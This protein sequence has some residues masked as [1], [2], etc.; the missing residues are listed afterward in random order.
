MGYHIRFY[1][2]SESV[3]EADELRISQVVYNLINNAITYTGEDKKITVHQNLSGGYVRIEVADTGE[4]IQPEMQD[5]IWDRY[6]K[7][8][9]EHKRSAVDVYKRQVISLQTTT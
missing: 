9:Q 5:V 8:D 6:Y 1:Y 3:V 2:D 7:V 4:G